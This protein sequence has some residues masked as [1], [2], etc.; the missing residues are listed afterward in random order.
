MNGRVY[1]PRTGR[2]LSPDPIIENPAFSQSWNS[3]S[4]VANS[5]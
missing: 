1:D 2:F 4:Y 3:Y 5:P